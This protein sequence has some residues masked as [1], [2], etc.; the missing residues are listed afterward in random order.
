MD[1]GEPCMKLER[2]Y[3]GKLERDTAG[4]L[5]RMFA[6]IL[7]QVAWEETVKLVVEWETLKVMQSKETNEDGK[8]HLVWRGMDNRIYSYI[9]RERERERERTNAYTHVSAYIFITYVQEYV[10]LN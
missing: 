8:T 7:D 1:S 6:G 3:K 10:N 2:F 9:Q 4:H 5:S